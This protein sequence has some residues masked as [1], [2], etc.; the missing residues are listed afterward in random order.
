MTS[1]EICDTSVVHAVGV[2]P[3]SRAWDVI[4]E[5]DVPFSELGEVCEALS[6]LV[7]R[8]ILETEASVTNMRGYDNGEYIDDLRWS[9]RLLR[10]QAMRKPLIQSR[11]KSA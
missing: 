6:S 2:R 11:R 10:Q 5:L 7:D 9:R 3:G 4:I 1:A 8:G